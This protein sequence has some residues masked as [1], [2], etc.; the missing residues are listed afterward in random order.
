MIKV[1][2]LNELLVAHNCLCAI[3][4][5]LNE[6]GGAMIYL[7]RSRFLKRQGLMLCVSDLLISVILRPVI[8][9]AG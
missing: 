8:L 2:Q 4:I 9:A 6:D 7:Y 5:Q 3:S 1:L